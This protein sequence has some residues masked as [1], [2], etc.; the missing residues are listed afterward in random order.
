[1]GVLYQF[2][3]SS[4]QVLPAIA[5]VIAG[6]LG[7]VT[8]ILPKKLSKPYPELQIMQS[9]F[10]AQILINL[11]ISLVLT[12]GV[13]NIEAVP[14]LAQF[15]YATS[16]LIANAMAIAGFKRLEPSVGSI[17]GT[18]EIIF[19]ILFGVGL[20]AEALPVSS[21]WGAGLII[22]ATILPEIK[23]LRKYR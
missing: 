9:F 18:T 23:K 20:F 5:T 21:F 19:G 22:L 7:S 14:W 13:A 1:M 16:M 15:G 2:S 3:V 4:Y 11:P 12:D 17:L 6:I 8:V 10:V